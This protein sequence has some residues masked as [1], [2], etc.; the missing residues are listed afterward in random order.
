VISALA[1]F[2]LFV[3]IREHHIATITNFFSIRDN[4]ARDLFRLRFAS[5]PSYSY[6]VILS[7]VAPMFVIC[8]FLAGTL[9]KSWALVLATFVL[10]AA[11]LSGKIET[12][13]KAPPALFLIQ[14][15][16][17]ALITRTNRISWKL[18]AFGGLVASL[19]I[20]AAARLIMIVPGQN[21]LI[22]TVYARVFEIENESLLE[23]FATFPFMHPYMWGANIRPIAELMGIPY[24]PSDSIVAYTWLG[25]HN[26]TN[27]SLF[28]AEAWADFSYGGVIVMSI[29][30]GLICRSID[31]V[32]LANGKSVVAIAVLGATF[33]GVFTLLTTALNTALLSGGLLLGPIVAA[34][35]IAPTRHL[36]TK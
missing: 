2:M 13:S 19:V 6:R 11:T 28:I 33:L 22:T 29:I 9:R 5:S 36:T 24:V 3:S 20:Y 26:V 34:T 31:L 35:L 14:L 7:A 16:L 4:D 17:A 1:V 27:P 18:A 10:F 32:F 23:N 25:T 12:L 30:A 15:M 21:S 8:G